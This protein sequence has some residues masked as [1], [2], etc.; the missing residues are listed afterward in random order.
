MHEL[1]PKILNNCFPNKTGI[2]VPGSAKNSDLSISRALAKK[3]PERCPSI[4][5]TQKVDP[6]KDLLAIIDQN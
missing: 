2:M 3:N 5:I 4:L 6:L 1:I